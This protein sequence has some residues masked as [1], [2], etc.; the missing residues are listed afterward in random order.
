M[1]YKV[2]IDQQLF[3]VEIINIHALP[4]RVLVD[5]ECF[6]IWPDGTHQVTTGMQS[7]PAPALTPV[8]PASQATQTP[9]NGNANVDPNQIKAPIPGLVLSIEI[10]PG[11]QVE[12][13]QQL[14]VL[15]AMKM[16]NLIRSP[17]AGTIAAVH[18]APGQTVA[19]GDLLMEYEPLEPAGK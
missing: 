19:H 7:Q 12:K 11:D 3:D 1:K 5:G 15:E 13:G 6:E 17:R 16:K 18:V 2:T 14:C 8:H 4:I 9:P 10:R